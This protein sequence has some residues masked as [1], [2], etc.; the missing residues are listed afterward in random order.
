MP[1]AFAKRAMEIDPNELAA[2]M[3][4]FKAQIE[5]RF[6]TDVQIRA[7]KEDGVAAA[8]QDVDRASILGPRGPDARA[9][10]TPRTSRT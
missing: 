9:S 8:F 6:K 4:A 1:R 10:S 3:L 5:R 2:S 7:D